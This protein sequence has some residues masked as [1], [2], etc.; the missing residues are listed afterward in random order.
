MFIDGLYSKCT[1][2]IGVLYHGSLSELSENIFLQSTFNKLLRFCKEK[3]IN[4]IAF[5]KK[6]LNETVQNF[7][8]INAYQFYLKTN[9]PE[10]TIQNKVN[11]DTLYIGVLGNLQFRKNMHNQVAAALIH[12]SSIVH[13]TNKSEYDYLNKENRIIEHSY[14]LSYI[15]FLKVMASMHIN[16]YVTYTETWGQLITESLALG[17]PCLAAN[18]S[19]ILDFHPDIKKLL[20]VQEFDNPMDIYK[21]FVIAIENLD[22]FKKEGP[23]YIKKLNNLSDESIEIFLSA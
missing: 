3:K 14:N 20:I 7:S 17:V 2:K 9:I 6:G 8:N 13:V 4:K 15:D 18:N 11:N 19:G 22:F 10:F 21:Q 16:F 23:M 5:N 12:K 1:S